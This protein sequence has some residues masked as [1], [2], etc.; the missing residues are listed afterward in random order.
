MVR[1]QVAAVVLCAMIIAASAT[2]IN[3]KA[4]QKALGQVQKVAKGRHVKMT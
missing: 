4:L 2:P 1:L 3:K